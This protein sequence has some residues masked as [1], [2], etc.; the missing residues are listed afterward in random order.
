MGAFHRP[1]RGTV[2]APTRHTNPPRLPGE[3]QISDPIL[4]HFWLWPIFPATYRP[5]G[6]TYGG[7]IGCELEVPYRLTNPQNIIAQLLLEKKLARGGGKEIV[8]I[9]SDLRMFFS[10]LT[11]PIWSTCVKTQ[12]LESH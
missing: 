6:G 2:C 3:G 8:Q 5:C 11:A 10:F 9:R 4:G 12:V 7:V 1:E